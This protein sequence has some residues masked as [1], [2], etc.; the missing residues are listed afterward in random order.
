MPIEA[1]NKSSE[2]DNE[3]MRR[4]M[5]TAQEASP[6]AAGIIKAA[7]S[8]GCGFQFQSMK[9][10]SGSYD[11]SGM[12]FLNSARSDKELIHTL[13][14]ECRH[15]D[16]PQIYVVLANN[17]R[18]NLQMCRAKEADAKA[19]ECAAAYEMRNAVPEVWQDFKAA[20]QGVAVAYVREKEQS[21]DDNKALEEAF[22]AWHDDTRYVDRYDSD[23]LDMLY[24]H[25]TRAGRLFLTRE[26]PPEEI[27]DKVCQKDGKTYLNDKSFMVSPRALTVDEQ[28]VWSKAQLV[29]YRAYD[30]YDF[31]DKSIGE[32]YTRSPYGE[33]KSRR[34]ET[35]PVQKQTEQKKQESQK[36][37]PVKGVSPE[38]WSRVVTLKSGQK[39]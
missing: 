21:K 8:K 27:A 17:I 15:A 12:V 32:L 38:L 35:A 10:C 30:N 4:L 39:R 33:V 2:T 28:K 1:V 3:R 16:Q 24:A 18:T 9:D 13:V 29:Y 37:T 11:P 22:K 23:T 31:K 20:N 19:F 14:H 25:S 7:I 34:K 26:I 6:V 5:Q 36:I